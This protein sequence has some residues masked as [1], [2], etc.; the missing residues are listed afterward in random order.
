MKSIGRKYKEILGVSCGLGIVGEQ[1]QPHRPPRSHGGMGACP[2]GPF[3]VVFWLLLRR[4][5]KSVC[6]ATLFFVAF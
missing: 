1:T 3:C 2:Q 6:E 5:F 4:G